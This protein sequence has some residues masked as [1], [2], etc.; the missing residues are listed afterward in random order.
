MGNRSHLYTGDY[1]VARQEWLEANHYRVVRV[2]NEDV[3]KNLEG[4]VAL[5]REEAS[6]PHP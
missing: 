3:M 2:T 6:R 1:D 5:I 4:V